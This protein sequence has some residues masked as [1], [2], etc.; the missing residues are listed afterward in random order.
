MRRATLLGR[1]PALCEV[2]KFS[3]VLL[4]LLF[5]LRVPSALAQETKSPIELY[6]AGQYEAAIAAGE[7]ANTGE[8]LAAAA[9]AALAIANLRD[10]PCLPCV[11]RAENL[12]R[13]SIS[14]DMNHPDAFVFLAVSLGYESRLVGTIR[15]QLS[16]YPEQ[17][18]QAIDH[19]LAVA[20]NDAF[21]LA[22]A[23]AWHIEVVRNGGILARPIFGARV[24]TGM[25]FFHRALA[26]DPENLVI[27]VQYALSLAG[28]AF[29]TYNEE[30]ASQLNAVARIEPRTAY[31]NALKQ[32]ADGLLELIKNDKRREFL[33]LVNRYQGYP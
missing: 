29:D 15:A 27:R 5:A 8:G 22:A 2:G 3:L 23:G 9:R 32:R 25:D 1:L 13:R 20:P 17:A 31:E 4:W 6:R 30:V 7:T 11:Q 21:S 16:H 24:D 33:A 10:A 19:A 14:L 28:Y 12:A 18:K 26:A